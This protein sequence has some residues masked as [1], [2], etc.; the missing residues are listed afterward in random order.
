MISVSSSPSSI[1]GVHERLARADMQSHMII[2]NIS[3]SVSKCTNAF[4]ISM[5]SIATPPS[6]II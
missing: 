2:L 5:T 3:S 4:F 1:D 6:S